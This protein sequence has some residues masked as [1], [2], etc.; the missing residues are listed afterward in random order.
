MEGKDQTSDQ[1]ANPLQPIPIGERP[2]IRPREILI[3]SVLNGYTITVDCQVVVF[4]TKEKMLS[5][6]ER[7]FKNPVQVEKEYLQGK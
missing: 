6:I 7:Y 5:E 3:R 4:E 2:R 1:C